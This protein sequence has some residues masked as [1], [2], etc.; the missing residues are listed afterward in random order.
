MVFLDA[1]YREPYHHD[2]VE[3]G[4]VLGLGLMERAGFRT[5]GL[6][7]LMKRLI[8]DA[9]R[10]AAGYGGEGL[11]PRHF[12]T[13]YPIEPVRLGLLVEA[14]AG[15]RAYL[16]PASDRAMLLG[17]TQ[18]L[19]IGQSPE[20]GYFIDDRFIV[21]RTGLSLRLPP[22]F[23]ARDQGGMIVGQ[24]PEGTA[25]AVDLTDIDHLPPAVR[26]ARA[27]VHL[28]DVLGRPF[29]ERG[30]IRDL[31]T[32]RLAGHDA[33]TFTARLP[34]SR[35][36]VD[37]RLM[38]IRFAN[39]QMARLVV[40]NPAR[41]TAKLANHIRELAF[42]LQLIDDLSLSPPIAT[43][44]LK[45]RRAFGGEMAG[46]LADNLADD[47]NEARHFLAVNGF[48]R[49]YRLARNEIYRIITREP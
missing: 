44:H 47:R 33:A 4:F 45:L 32:F 30:L 3:R 34:V 8:E 35:G 48:H 27:H 23:S 39:D 16:D 15:G 29:A 20:R 40:M 13:T 46:D 49:S 19:T 36:S 25:F 22:G 38:A 5:Q 26:L 14:F 12:A 1:R 43:M 2:N 31:E 10:I 24:G 17:E 11:D 21:P 28:R 6:D 18:N 41:I 42:S 9:K 37:F 7:Q